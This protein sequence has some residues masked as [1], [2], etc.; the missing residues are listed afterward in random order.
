MIFRNMR[1]K[2]CGGLDCPDW[3]LAEI[4]TMAKISALKVRQLAQE[5]N[6][7]IFNDI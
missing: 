6:S 2:F 1:F 3:L 7:P 4:A 5:V